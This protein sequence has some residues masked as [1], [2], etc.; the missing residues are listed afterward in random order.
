MK[1]NTDGMAKHAI[2]DPSVTKVNHMLEVLRLV[3]PWLTWQDWR[4]L[5]KLKNKAIREWCHSDGAAISLF[6]LWQEHTES[7]VEIAH[8]LWDLKI[9]YAYKQIPTFVGLFV[10]DSTDGGNVV[11]LDPTVEF[12]LYRSSLELSDLEQ[13]IAGNAIH[14]GSSCVKDD[15]L[16]MRGG[17]RWLHI[18]I[19]DPKWKD[20]IPPY[21]F[22]KRAAP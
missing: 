9:R 22:L 18:T 6:E 5:E 8:N 19:S 11:R 16:P 10:N 13:K 17:D 21:Y 20:S 7:L 4:K 15:P 3:G 14:E 12:A 2:M 1:R